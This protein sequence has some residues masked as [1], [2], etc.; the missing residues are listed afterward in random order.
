[1]TP[2]ERDRPINTKSLRTRYLGNRLWELHNLQQYSSAL[3]DEDK[4][5]SK[6]HVKV[7]ARTDAIFGGGVP[8]DG[9]TGRLPP[10]SLVF[11][12]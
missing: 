8:V 10:Y 3:G 5:R 11:A 6:G 2:C 1:M 4:K 12:R 9:S 7:T